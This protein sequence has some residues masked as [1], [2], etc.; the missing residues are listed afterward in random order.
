MSELEHA[1]RDT[2]ADPPVDPPALRN[3]L[4]DI[5]DRLYKRQQR[6]RRTSVAALAASAVAA[7][8][9]PI[10]VYGLPTTGVSTNSKSSSAGAERAAAAPSAVAVP[11]AVR[12][13]AENLA[14]EPGSRPDRQ[15]EWVRTTVGRFEAMQGDINHNVP[16]GRQIYVV[17]LRGKFV[18]ETCSHPRG[19]KTPTGIAEQVT[20]AVDPHLSYS[21]F[22]LTKRPYDLARLGVV[23]TFTLR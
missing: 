10:S 14:K 23:H 15:V 9:V 17:Q 7:F 8:V 16:R 4:H 19:A 22:G 3:P 20:L 12:R 21:N 18:C 5:E 11:A 13:A 1:L 6:R 2:L